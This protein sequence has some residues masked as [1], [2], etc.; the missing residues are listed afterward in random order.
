[1]AAE[2]FPSN[3]LRMAMARLSSAKERRNPILAL[4]MS[5]AGNGAVDQVDSFGKAKNV[6]SAIATA[7]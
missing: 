5:Q 3:F 2:H 4:A 7:S 1:V 6:S